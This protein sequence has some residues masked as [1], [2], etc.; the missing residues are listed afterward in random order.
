MPQADKP[1][2]TRRALFAAAPAIALAAVAAPAMA[3]TGNLMARWEALVERRN[4]MDRYRWK[5]DELDEVVD[6]WHDDIG[7]LLKAPIQS[8][9]DAIAKLECAGLMVDMGTRTD[10]LDIAAVGQ[11]AT[12][13]RG[14]P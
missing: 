6:R 7:E 8:R 4:D 9:E 14:T 3:D 2:T 13:L 5:D 10:E 1:S 12:Y 11:V